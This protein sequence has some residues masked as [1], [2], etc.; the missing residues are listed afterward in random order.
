[1]AN[2]RDS[3]SIGMSFVV[4]SMFRPWF[5]E[6]SSALTTKYFSYTTIRFFNLITGMYLEITYQNPLQTTGK[7]EL[8]YSY[9]IVLNLDEVKSSLQIFNSFIDIWPKKIFFSVPYICINLNSRI[10]AI[11]KNQRC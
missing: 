1:M 10:S 11:W 3:A 7:F 2:I 4:I 9:I 6:G 5:I 8:Y